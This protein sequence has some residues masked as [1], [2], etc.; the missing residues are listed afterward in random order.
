MAEPLKAKKKALLS[1][2]ESTYGEDPIPTSV[3]N[4]VIIKNIELTP[5]EME[6]V[7]RDNVKGYYGN[8]EETLALIYAKLSFETELTGSGTAGTVPPM[9]HLLRSCAMAETIFTTAHTATAAAGA[10]NSMTLGVTASAVNDAYAGLTLNTTVGTG[11]GQSRVI[12]SYNGTTKVAVFTENWDVPPDATT[13]YVIPAQVTYNRITDD[14]ESI[15]HYTYFGKVLHKMVGARGTVSLQFPYTKTPM[16][17]FSYT[18]IYVPVEDADAP[19]ISFASRKKPLAVNALNTKNIRLHGYVGVAF[20]DLSIDM[21]NEI[22]FR[23]LPGAADAVSFTDSKPTGSLTQQATTV[24]TKDWFSAIKNIDVGTLSVT[25]GVAVGNTIK[26]DCCRTQLLKPSY[27]ESAGVQMLQ[28]PLKFLPD[29]GN[30]EFR[31]TFF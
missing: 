20:E 24:A 4:G 1:K 16:L 19:A 27:S 3:A 15:T 30:D 7:P 5:M 18:G 6:T 12:K 26:V 11:L 14:S 31:L 10:V 8:D 13:V 25:H 29:A 23:S 28:T 9:S 2:I 22:V 17:K 21:A